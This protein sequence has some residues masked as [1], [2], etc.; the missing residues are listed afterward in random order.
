MK[1]R[2]QRMLAVG[3]AVAGVA[4]AAALT[5]N[6]IFALADWLSKIVLSAK[7]ARSI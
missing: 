5:L 2:Q 4:I 7:K 1:P 3:L 6:A